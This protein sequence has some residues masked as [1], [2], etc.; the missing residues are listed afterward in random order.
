MKCAVH[1]EAEASGFCRNCGKPMCPACVRPV[2]DVLYCEDCLAKV[3]G[4]S[5]PPP[6][7]VAPGVVPAIVPAVDATGAPIAPSPLPPAAP[8]PGGNPGLAFLL[9]L[10]PGLGAIYNGEYNKALIH[11]VVFAA[12]IVGLSSDVG[13]GADVALSFVLVGF[14]FYMAID[15]MKTVRAR[16]AG[17]PV[18]DPLEMWSK[19]RPVGPLILI[20]VGALFLLNNFGFFDFF[21]VRQ[22]FWPLVLIGVGVLMLRNRVGGQN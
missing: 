6:P 18:Q 3:M 13:S 14:V 12:I 4:L 5:A 2:R 17:E 8:R 19:A 11:I 21:R 15:A 7:A 10:V 9:G 20:A 1:P 22:I 16:N